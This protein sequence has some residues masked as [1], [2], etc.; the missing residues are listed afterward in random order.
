MENNQLASMQF[1]QV[2]EIQEL[3]PNQSGTLP[4]PAKFSV[5]AGKKV[6]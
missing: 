2:K 4:L 5:T 3:N 1:L 6:V